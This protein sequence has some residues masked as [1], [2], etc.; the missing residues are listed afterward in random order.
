MN[1]QIDLQA[2]IKNKNNGVSLQHQASKLGLNY[3]T[4]C[5]RIARYKKK[6]GF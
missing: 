4:L 6:N 5:S 2:V 3:K 1:N